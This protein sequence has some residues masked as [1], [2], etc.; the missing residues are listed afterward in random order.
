VTF[1]P[2][3]SVFRLSCSIRFGMADGVSPRSYFLDALAGVGLQAREAV[4]GVTPFVEAQAGAGL[5][6]YSTFHNTL[7]SL[8]WT[9]GAEAGVQ[10]FLVDSFHVVGAVGWARPVVRIRQASGEKQQIDVYGD[11]VTVR[12]GVGF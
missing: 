10:L 6:M 11:T 2:V 12:L 8:G 3:A 9:F 7:P 5:R 1:F 4:R